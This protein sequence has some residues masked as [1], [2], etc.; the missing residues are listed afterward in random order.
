MS[1]SRTSCRCLRNVRDHYVKSEHSVRI[2]RFLFWNDVIPANVA[3]WAP[4][5]AQP[6]TMMAS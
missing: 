2:G 6:K 5:A 4:R 3:F 1:P